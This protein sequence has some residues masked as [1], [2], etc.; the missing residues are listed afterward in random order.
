[1]DLHYKLRIGYP[2][3]TEF[4]RGI[5]N[6]RLGTLLRICEGLEIPPAKLLELAESK[7]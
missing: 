3:L 6:P 2:T 7:L 1:M 5:G 4:E